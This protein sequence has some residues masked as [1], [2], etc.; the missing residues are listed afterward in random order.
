MANRKLLF[1]AAAPLLLLLG[2]MLS[3]RILSHLPEPESDTA[4]V[5]R[6][7]SLP[8]PTLVP[9]DAA[10][11]K[12]LESS[13]RGQ[14]SAIRKGDYAAAITFSDASFRKT[15][16]P[17]RF[18]EMVETGYKAMTESTKE[19]FETGQVSDIAAN[20]RVVLT[21]SDHTRI[22]YV[23][24]LLHEGNG[25][26]VQACSPGFPVGSVSETIEQG[27]PTQRGPESGPP[28]APKL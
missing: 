28:T 17:K 11:Q 19:T 10:T 13:V 14:L 8:A 7:I 1:I 15:W 21:T 23:F 18:Q 4:S 6:E 3:F 20:L 24:N 9:A 2:M 26:Y 16:N 22:A 5:V 25:W 27:R 12:A